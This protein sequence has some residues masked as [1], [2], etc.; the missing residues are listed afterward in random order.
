M[1]SIDDINTCIY[2]NYNYEYKLLCAMRQAQLDYDA[3]TLGELM[4]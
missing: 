1:S 2:I 3:P 4:Y